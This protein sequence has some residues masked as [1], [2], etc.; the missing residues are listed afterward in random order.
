MRFS[1]TAV[2]FRQMIF[3]YSICSPHA[4]KLIDRD[5]EN[6]HWHGSGNPQFY[7]AVAFEAAAQQFFLLYR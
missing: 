5:P 3:L 6:T 2:N 7:M 4:M 1:L